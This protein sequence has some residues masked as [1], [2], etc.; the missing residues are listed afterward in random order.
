MLIFSCLIFGAQSAG[1][2]RRQFICEGWDVYYFFVF[3][4]QAASFLPDYAK[5]KAVAIKM[6]E[7]FTRKPQINKWESETTTKL[8]DDKFNGNICFN[9][10]QF[11][12]PTKP[13][14]RVVNNLSLT[15]KKGERIALVGS[16]GKCVYQLSCWSVFLILMLVK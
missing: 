11:H 5:A 16:R 10:I 3:K 8:S 9:G 6:L 12:Y 4:G 7:L 13:N 1:N 15:V 14:V 2:Y